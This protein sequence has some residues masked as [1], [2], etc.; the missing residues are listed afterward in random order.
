MN[1]CM[2][3]Y[4]LVNNGIG[5]V[6]LTYSIEL[7]KHGHLVTILVG[8]LVDEA[9]IKEAEH[10][11]ISI[12]RLPNKK[13]N[14]VAYFKALKSALDGG[15]Y[16]IVHVH[17]NSGMILPEIVIARISGVAAVIGH[18]HNT[19]CN[20]PVLHRLL[21]P[22]VTRLCDARLAC[23]RD[24]GEWLY[25]KSNFTVL[26]NAFD[27]SR[28]CFDSESRNSIREALKIGRRTIVLGDVAR[29]NPEKNHS[30]LIK[31]FEEYHSRQHDSKLMI[32]GGGPGISFVKELVKSSPAKDSILL[33]G[34][35]ADPSKLYSCMDC[36]V[37]P[38]LYEGLGIVLVEA[39]TSGLECFVSEN[40]PQEACVTDRYHVL[41]L[42]DGA[43]AWADEIFETMER[44]GLENRFGEHDARL[45]RYDIRSGY[46]ILEDVYENIFAN[47]GHR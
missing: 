1:I 11:G 32:V 18:C 4:N 40:I 23:S 46:R 17:G 43:K 19:G 41:K 15:R 39:Q 26:P 24:A 42:D 5:K 13:R 34:D 45:S 36:F 2:V 37:F 27:L 12:V 16:D 9:K 28:Y 20:H 10:C 21:K 47:G 6:V 25:G 7:V 38:S 8:G 22:I 3:V 31:V 33:F 30:F 35:I 44:R 29:L 14:T